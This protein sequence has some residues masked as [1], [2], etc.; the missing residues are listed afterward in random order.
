MGKEGANAFEL[1]VG[2]LS[3]KERTIAE[4]R[5]WLVE[6]E[7]DEAD[8]EEALARLISIGELDDERF[9]HAYAEDKRDLRGWGPERI[10]RTLITRGIEQRLAEL[11]ALTET[12]DDQAARAA[13]MLAERG[14]GLDDDAA[15]GRALA[16]LARRGY[17]YEVA[18]QA[19]RLAQR[20]PS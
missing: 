17:E 4:L 2:A 12:A 10:R 16:F 20:A 5:E 14:D 7:L 11:A 15:R 9:A 6:R 19:V 8:V 1:A 13:R 3:R 18:Y